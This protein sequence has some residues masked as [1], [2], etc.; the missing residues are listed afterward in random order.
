MAAFFKAI[1]GEIAFFV[2]KYSKMTTPTME[3]KRLHSLERLLLR[4][5][6]IVEEVE[7]WHI[8]N[9][10]TMDRLNLLRKEMYKGYFTVDTLKSEGLEA[11]GY[12]VSH[13]FVLSKFNP[14]KRIFFSS[15]DTHREQVLQQVIDNLNNMIYDANELILF[16][17]NSPLLYKKPY[18]MHLFTGK[19]MFG[20]QMEMERIINFLM[21]K[22]HHSDMESMDVLP[23]V[24]N[25]GLSPLA[26]I[27]LKS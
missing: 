12:N 22:E 15:I 27:F 5:H 25:N 1:V 9:Q 20:R 6:V 18:D 11:R 13:S 14:A 10:A 23:V 19:C 16:L 26:A 4:V 2:D 7:G 17:K 3:D 24:L 8:T 21:Q